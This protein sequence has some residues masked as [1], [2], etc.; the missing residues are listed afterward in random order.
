MNE[1]K[2]TTSTLEEFQ[3]EFSTLKQNFYSRIH[4]SRTTK[5]Q[6]FPKSSARVTRLL[7][8]LKTRKLSPE[9]WRCIFTYEDLVEDH[10][11][12]LIRNPRY[13]ITFTI[14]EGF[15]DFIHLRQLYRRCPKSEKTN[16]R[17]SQIMRKFAHICASTDYEAIILQPQATRLSER[18]PHTPTGFECDD[19]L[20]QEDLMKFYQ[21]LG[22]KF[23]EE[24]DEMMVKLLS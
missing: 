17:A 6:F 3:K 22:Y 8:L 5:E 15:E 14:D 9:F 20:E 19:V 2:T 16:Y 10:F 12:C 4:Y 24:G 23:L 13:C 11:V 7:K 18:L 1:L 21:K